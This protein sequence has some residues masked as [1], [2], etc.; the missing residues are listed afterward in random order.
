M[1]N[2][3]DE[4]KNANTEYDKCD[5]DYAGDEGPGDNDYA[6]YQKFGR[7][8]VIIML[9]FLVMT[10]AVT[11]YSTYLEMPVKKTMMKHH[12]LEEHDRSLLANCL[13]ECSIE[14]I[15]STESIVA[16]Y[17]FSNRLFNFYSQ[18]LKEV[19]EKIDQMSPDESRYSLT[20]FSQKVVEG[21][22]GYPIGKSDTLLTMASYPQYA[23]NVLTLS[24][25][26]SRR[27]LENAKELV[28]VLES[29]CSS[30]LLMYGCRREAKNHVNKIKSTQEKLEVLRQK[31]EAIDRYH[32]I[33]ES[34]E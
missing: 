32:V 20:R 28:T 8:A 23:A 17:E 2:N 24:S 1:K 26:L 12:I 21:H 19:Y 29:K 34:N 15:S 30:G 7:V 11:S 5:L 16:L 3:I 22:E 10:I 27:G 14:S 18:D 31:I 6:R 13:P 9:V 33:G 25:Q 4:G